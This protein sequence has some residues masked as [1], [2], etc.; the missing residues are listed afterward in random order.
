MNKIRNDGY[1]S[2]RSVSSIPFFTWSKEYLVRAAISNTFWNLLDEYPDLKVKVEDVLGEDNTEGY[3]K[4]SELD[5]QDVRF[6]NQ[7]KRNSHV[8]VTL[9]LVVNFRKRSASIVKYQLLNDENAS[10]NRKY[11]TGNI[12]HFSSLSVMFVLG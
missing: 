5:E 9:R 6:E 1:T 7:H 12:F 11:Q 10:S 8:P 2:Y 3:Y 4:L